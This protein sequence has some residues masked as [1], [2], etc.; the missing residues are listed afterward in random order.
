MMNKTWFLSSR[1]DGQRKDEHRIS[2]YDMTR[3]R[4]RVEEVWRR[5]TWALSWS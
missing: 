5:G 3:E 2:K 1:A 4:V